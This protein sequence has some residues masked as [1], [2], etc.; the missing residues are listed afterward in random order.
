MEGA[1]KPNDVAEAEEASNEP[2]F[3]TLVNASGHRQELDRNFGL[4]SKCGLAVTS[5]NAWLE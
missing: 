2:V 1:T 3:G 4:L 5:G